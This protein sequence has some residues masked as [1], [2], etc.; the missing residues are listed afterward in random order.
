[1]LYT[2][3]IGIICLIVIMYIFDIQMSEIRY[4]TSTKKYLLKDDNYQRYKEYLMTLFFTYIN[5]N[6][7]GIKKLGINEFFYNCK[8]DIVKFE[9]SKVIYSSKTNEFIF[10]TPYEFTTNRNDYYKL[11][12]MGESFQL[13]FIKT[14]YTNN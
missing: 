10:I 12:A 8:N 4:A 2:V 6:N 9:K 5:E 14:I 13:V 1:M 7:D 3:L 11:Q